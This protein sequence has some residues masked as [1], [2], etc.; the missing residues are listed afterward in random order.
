[1]HSVGP[2]Q[3]RNILGIEGALGYL[4]LESDCLDDSSGSGQV[5]GLWLFS[6]F[7]RLVVIDFLR[8][9]LLLDCSSLDGTWLDAKLSIVGFILDE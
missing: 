8:R 5:L 4:L 7:H 3:F 9:Y 6:R 2:L 1:M